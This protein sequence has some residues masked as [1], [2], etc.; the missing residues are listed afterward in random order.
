MS[1]SAGSSSNNESEEALVFALPEDSFEIGAGAI[2]GAEDLGVCP[3]EA[4]GEPF[5][6]RAGGL[7][8]LLAHARPVE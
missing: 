7:A 1:E 3:A 6:E 5:F 8:S 4:P 2:R